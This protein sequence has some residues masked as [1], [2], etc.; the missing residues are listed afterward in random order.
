MRGELGLGFGSE[1]KYE[2]GRGRETI[3]YGKTALDAEKII[4]FHSGDDMNT[5]GYEHQRPSA[6]YQHHYSSPK[7]GTSIRKSLPER[8]IMQPN[9]T[10][11]MQ[12]LHSKI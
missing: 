1:G 10:Q 3:I 12:T 8:S 6:P 11:L 9:Q 7:R 4:I 2:T 5:F